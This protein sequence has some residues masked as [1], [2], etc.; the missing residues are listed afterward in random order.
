MR[1]KT[2]FS[3]VLV[4]I[5]GICALAQDGMINISASGE[6][7]FDDPQIACT[8]V[9]GYREFAILAEGADRNG[10]DRNADPYLVA[11]DLDHPQE[12]YENND[13]T[14]L[15]SNEK[16]IL[17]NYLRIPNDIFDSALLLWVE[18]IRLCT[19]AYEDF[20]SRSDINL[21]INDITG[22]F[23]R[24]ADSRRNDGRPSLGLLFPK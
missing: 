16:D 4:F 23:S 1:L 10:A 15:S 20:L 9:A 19:Y 18:D 17:R 7:T 22:A 24:S 6:A 3:F 8:I 11:L 2:L 12:T 14:E 21:Q 5:P 13:W